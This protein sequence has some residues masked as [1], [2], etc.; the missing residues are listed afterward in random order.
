MN[1]KPITPCNQTGSEQGDYRFVLEQPGK[2]MLFVIGLN[3]SKADETQSDPTI[4]KVME[5]AERAEYDGFAMLNLSAERQT[6]KWE[7][8]QKQ[9]DAMHQKNLEAIAEL[10]GRYPTADILVAF[11]N[12]I[13]VKTYLKQNFWDICN[14]LSNHRGAWK[15]IGQLTVKKN[16]RHPLYAKY[17]WGLTDFDLKGYVS[18]LR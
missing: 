1:Y 5:F 9:N 7:M 18:K 3:S 13:V 2:K 15:Q 14:V 10:A 11:G 17:A 12:D 4:R 6:I 8:S 16:P